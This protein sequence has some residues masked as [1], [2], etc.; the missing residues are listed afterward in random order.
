MLN[1]KFKFVLR[2]H[3]LRTILIIFALTIVYNI[4]SSNVHAFGDWDEVIVVNNDIT[5]NSEENIEMGNSGADESNVKE[6]KIENQE[7]EKPEVDK[8]ILSVQESSTSKLG[9]LRNGSV[10]I[11]ESING[12]SISAANYTDVVYYIKRQAVYES[13]TYYLISKEPSSVNGVVGWVKEEDV[14]T[15]DHKGVDK[16]AMTFIINGKGKATTKAWGGNKDAVY[17][18]LSSYK[19]QLFQVNLTEQVGNNTW[20]RGILAGKRVWLHSSQVE[21]TDVIESNTSKLG[22]IRNGIVKIYNSINGSSFSAANYTDAVY[23]IKKQA[24]YATETYYLISTKPSAV[25]GVVGWV[26]AND[27]STHDHKG[28]DNKAKSFFINGNGKA[29]STAWGGHKDAVYT[30][31][32]SYKGQ[33]FQVNLTEKVGNNIWYRGTLA[34]KTVWVHSSQVNNNSIKISETSKLGH[35]RNKDVKIYREISGTSFSA[36]NYTDAVYY[37]KNQAEYAGENYYLISTQPSSVNGVVG[38]VKSKD[39]S[40]NDH[41]GIDNKAKTFFINGKGKATTKTWGG[42]KDTVYPNLNAYK[43]QLFQVHL[44]EQVGSNTWYR[45]TLAGKTVWLHSTQVDNTS[46]KVNETS[47]LGHLRNGSVKIYKTI[48]GESFSAANYTD[49]VYYIKRQAES[50]DETYFMISTQPSAVSGVVGWVKAKDISTHDHKGVDKNRK[51]FYINGIG[52]ATSKIWG[53]NKDAVYKDLNKNVNDIFIVNLTEKVGDNTWYRG[54]LEGKQVWVHSSSLEKEIITF[55]QQVINLIN[56]ERKR[57][58]LSDLQ[59]DKKLMQSAGAKSKDMHQNNYFSHTSPV[60]GDL[61]DLMRLFDV[62]YR[63]AGEN[64]AKGYTTPENVVNGWMNSEGHRN[65]ILHKNYTHIG[66]G[67]VKEGNHWTQHFIWK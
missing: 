22:H 57:I 32:N 37:I 45:G 9:H 17:P 1:N 34:G 21:S 53:G 2:K 63:L 39:I 35:L 33:L 8:R 3:T 36:T 6:S 67:Y 41:K 44:T 56:V 14:S 50:A 24:E 31:L 49:A 38:W 48:N 28:F 59:I 7:I 27:L 29:T 4:S 65:N 54:L 46:I 5:S 11:Y 25:N 23:Y 26:K 30:N 19:G 12:K 40:T 66:V 52:K 64:I 18:N 60:L 55:E 43:D 42:H 20:Y 61:K 10:K 62:E 13:D 58:G 15:H 16:N 51:V 47:K